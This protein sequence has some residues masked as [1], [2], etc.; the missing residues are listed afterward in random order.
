MSWKPA[1]TRRALA[2]PQTHGWDSGRVLGT[3]GPAPRR[4]AGAQGLRAWD[5]GGLQHRGVCTSLPQKP[6]PYNFHPFFSLPRASRVRSGKKIPKVNPPTPAP[7]VRSKFPARLLTWTCE[8][9]ASEG[10]WLFRPGRG[11]RQTSPDRPPGPWKPALR[12]GPVRGEG[13]LPQAAGR[14]RFPRRA[15]QAGGPEG[16]LPVGTGTRHEGPRGCSP[17]L[18]AC[19]PRVSVSAC[20]LLP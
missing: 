11:R 20:A 1:D 16:V 18:R 3:G 7:R 12:S 4:G 6:K 5:A 13:R 2:V 17:A 14:A 9:C 8:L 19:G 15:C 10:Q